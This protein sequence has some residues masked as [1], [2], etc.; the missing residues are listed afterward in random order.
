MMN[1]VS[2]FGSPMIPL[3]Y[4][5]TFGNLIEDPNRD[6]CRKLTHLYS[7]EIQEIADLLKD[8]IEKPRQTAW[9]PDV[10]EPD[11][12]KV[13]RPPKY[14]YVNRLYFVLE[15]MF[16]IEGL[17]KTEAYKQYAKSSVSEDRKHILKAINKILEDEVRWPTS[18]ERAALREGFTGIFE[19]AVGIMD[20]TEHPY[21]K[22]KDPEKE[23]D[24]YS[25][26]AGDNTMKTLDVI[27]RY[28][29]FIW[30]DPLVHRYF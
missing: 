23:H 1:Q 3:S 26:K 15:W 20:V 4:V 10:K 11:A 28:G 22:S 24:T 30:V 29:L 17:Y 14:D 13:G 5:D 8:E 18:E 7:W 16:E 2:K 21:K 19:N 12:S 25:G 9:R 27:E 6:Y